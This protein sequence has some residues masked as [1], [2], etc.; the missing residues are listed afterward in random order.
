MDKID[1]I[2]WL[3]HI[4]KD[5]LTNAEQLKRVHVFYRWKNNEDHCK[6]CKDF[7]EAV[8]FV[9]TLNADNLIWL[10]FFWKITGP[11]EEW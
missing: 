5:G 3:N 4:N 10:D 1:Y 8:S 9:N 11:C 2:S 7:K 6:T